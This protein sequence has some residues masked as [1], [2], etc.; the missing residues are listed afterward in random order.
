MGDSGKGTRRGRLRHDGGRGPRQS[1]MTTGEHGRSRSARPSLCLC[2]VLSASDADSPSVP[3]SSPD[4]LSFE[5]FQA[6]LSII[7]HEVI[8]EFCFELFKDLIVVV[9]VAVVPSSTACTTSRTPLLPVRDRA[10]DL[11][12]VLVDRCERRGTSPSRGTAATV[13]DACQWY[14]QR[15][16][17]GTGNSTP[18]LLLTSWLWYVCLTY[19]RA[20]TEGC[21][22]R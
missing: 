22:F 8:V 6:L 15:R 7:S 1:A 19:A 2:L 21:S 13:R 9:V 16:A 18:S 11:V 5:L 12:V 4:L 20:C 3:S 10:E 17:R 14:V